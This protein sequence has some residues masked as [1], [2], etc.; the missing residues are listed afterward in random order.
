MKDK[1]ITQHFFLD[2]FL[3]FAAMGKICIKKATVKKCI[4]KL[5]M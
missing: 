4:G 3:L 5:L 1:Q 2:T